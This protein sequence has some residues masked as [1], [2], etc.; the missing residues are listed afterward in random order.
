MVRY[1]SSDIPREIIKGIE[2]DVIFLGKHDTA[3]KLFTRFR[4]HG[5]SVNTD[6]WISFPVIAERIEKYLIDEIRKQSVD[7][8]ISYHTNTPETYETVTVSWLNN[9]GEHNLMLTIGVS[10]V[11]DIEHALCLALFFV[12]LVEEGEGSGHRDSGGTSS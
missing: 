12:R 9:D 10:G 1:R 5:A 3:V 4:N 7:L 6:G 11:E 2:K 8:Y